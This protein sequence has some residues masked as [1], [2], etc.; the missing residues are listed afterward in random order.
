M[1]TTS[2]GSRRIKILRE[3]VSQKIA[4]GEVIDR[5]AA[6]VRELLD[7][8]LDAGA[9]EITVS[10]EDGGVSHIRVVD[11]GAGMDKEDLE[12]C[13]QPHATSKIEHEDDLLEIFSLGFRGEALSSVAACSRL[14][15]IS[16]TSSEGS[17]YRLA[18]ENG[19]KKTLSPSQGKKGT[20]VDVKD[21]FY[22]L[23][24]RKRFLKSTRA[25]TSQCRT[26]FFEK[27]LPFPDVTFRFSS[28]GDVKTVLPAASETGFLERIAA[29]H[30]SKLS[31]EHLFEH[32]SGNGGEDYTIT[33]VGAR[34]EITRHDRKLIQ[35]YANRRR[36]FDY[37]LIQAVEYGFSQYIAGG[38][39]PI[40]FVFITLPPDRIDF[41]IHPAKKEARFK[42]AQKVH[43]DIGITI[44]QALTRY[45]LS[46]AGSERSMQSFQSYQSSL[47][48]GK[49]E[50]GSKTGGTERSGPFFRP[51]TRT[52]PVP[53]AAPLSAAP[54]ATG[55]G[56]EEPFVYHGQIFNLFLLAEYGE[57]FY[58]IDQH[59]A[60]ERIIYEK[61]ISKQSES[62]PLLI[63]IPFTVNEY[64]N[65]ILELS[66]RKLKSAGIAVS[67]VKGNQWEIT[68]LPPYV[69]KQDLV[70][71]IK[72]ALVEPEKLETVLYAD[73]S[74][75][76]AVKDGEVVAPDFAGQLIH[77]VFSLE[78]S[79][80]PH[81]RPAWYAVTR[82]ELFYFV[83]R[84]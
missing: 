70:K 78:N 23:P 1:N 71:M 52:P 56:S 75:K 79:R 30:A 50:Y 83:G 48:S 28:D 51:D 60:H 7:N 2:D 76:A 19:K 40:C 46:A 67:K 34:P 84:K 26:V 54:L 43:H 65:E 61:L 9:G 6:V 3:S 73:I 21:L 82:E 41:N 31:K 13:W 12:L 38:S 39:F 17:A 49:G 80:C 22:S 47:F 33:I 42:D 59:A 62:N 27:V 36:V 32:S 10:I 14:E 63:P 8:A 11:D 4:A 72:H 37:S 45:N 69:P 57:T 77:D 16:K 24:A 15:I 74:C 44:K 5:P 58:I 35:I 66:A 64:E 55:E 81:G 18:V 25:E 53:S 29:V 20:I 68:A